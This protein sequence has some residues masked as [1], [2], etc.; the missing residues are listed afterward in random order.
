MSQLDAIERALASL[1]SSRTT[2]AVP[3]R[4][5]TKEP[6][7]VALIGAGRL[8]QYYIEAYNLFEDTQLVGI[9]EPN[10]ERAA[11]VR[12][13]FGVP[14]S[15]KDT[16]SMLDGCGPEIVTIATPGAYFQ[17]AV[18]RCAASNT[19]LAVQCEK[20]FGGPVADADAMVEVRPSLG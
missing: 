15:Y 6:L 9:V 5:F 11:A 7:R 10:P 4:D 14:A 12:D 8:G 3:T 16:Q 1:E 2:L 17:D 13:K 19:V 20:P 18:L